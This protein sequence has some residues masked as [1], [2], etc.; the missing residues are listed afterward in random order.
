MT[1][2]LNAIDNRMIMFCELYIIIYPLFV[3]EC[4]RESI[5]KINELMKN[6]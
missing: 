3:I 4:I 5:P 1:I 6:N 2:I